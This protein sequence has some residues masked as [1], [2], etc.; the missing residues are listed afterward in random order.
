MGADLSQETK[1]MSLKISGLHH[2]T[3]I[4]GDP[5]ANYDFY[6]GVLGLRLVKKTVNFDD[7]GTY[8]FYFGDRFGNPG[9]IM[10]FFPWQEARRGSPGAGQA[11]STVFSIPQDSLGYW[12]DRLSRM[13]FEA[14]KLTRFGSE[15]LAF[16]DLDGLKLELRSSSKEGRPGW[17]N[18]EIPIENSIRGFESAT[19]SVTDIEKTEDLLT[20]VMGYAKLL[21]E[22]SADGGQVRFVAA[23][24]S[25]ANYLDVDVRRSA[26]VG[27]MGA[28]SVHHVAFRATDDEEQI[29]WRDLLLEKGY[30]VSPVMDRTYFRSI[31]FREPG[32][33]LFEIATDPPGFTFD[34][35]VEGLGGE[36]KIPLWLESRRDEIEDSL[37]TLV[38]RS[39]GAILLAKRVHSQSNSS[40]GVY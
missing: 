26:S 2:V 24:N 35:T 20:N 12:S 29:K 40:S 25:P 14:Q 22:T 16:H 31:Y 5:Q 15:G 10:T 32:G 9:S 27:R 13:G 19:L 11:I 36:L 18:S 21:D 30:H 37:P 1:T 17:D 23:G 4:A 39:L 8:H 6:T 34:E 7:P 33:T 3:A 28:G 38:T